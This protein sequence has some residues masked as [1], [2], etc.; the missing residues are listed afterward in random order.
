LLEQRG[1]P[2]MNLDLYYGEHTIGDM[3]KKHG[4]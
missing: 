2:G 1:I 4:E 3:R